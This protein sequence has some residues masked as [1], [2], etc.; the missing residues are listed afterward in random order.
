[1]DAPKYQQPQP[2][3]AFVALQQQAED[4]KIAATQ[5]DMQRAT[6]LTRARYGAP[7]SSDQ[8]LARYGTMLASGG[9]PA[10]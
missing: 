1:M 8:I 2:D 6:M 7:M 5:E 4:Q 10:V 9:G 3:P